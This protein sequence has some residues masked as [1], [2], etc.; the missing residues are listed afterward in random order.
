MFAIHLVF[1]FLSLQ[2]KPIVYSCSWIFFNHIVIYETLKFKIFKNIK[3]V[4][5]NSFDQY[6]FISILY[7]RLFD[8]F[9]CDFCLWSQIAIR[10][11]SEMFLFLPY[12]NSRAPCALLQIFFTTCFWILIKLQLL[13]TKSCLLNCVTI[14]L[15][16]ISN[17][18]EYLIG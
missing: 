5:Q 9:S 17:I 16:W 1:F 7:S 18:T 13:V 6:V 15:K 12:F 11:K 3:E 2:A 8:K 4:V 14:R 10:E